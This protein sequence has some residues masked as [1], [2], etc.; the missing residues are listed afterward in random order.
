MTKKL[1]TLLAFPALLLVLTGSS[2]L[3]ADVGDAMKA[4][5]PFSF[6]VDNTTLPA[7]SYWIQEADS[8]NTSVFTI[9][10][11]NDKQAVI[12]ETEEI[13]KIEPSNTSKLV[14]DVR[15]GQHFLAQIWSE[16]R[17]VGHEVPPSQSMKA[18]AMNGTKKRASVTVNCESTNNPIKKG[19]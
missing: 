11:S 3:W 4:E 14:F 1:V 10:S 16:G 5:I 18:L 19:E 12:F 8:S 15:D 9:R 6:S 13:D 17:I 7:G 2:L